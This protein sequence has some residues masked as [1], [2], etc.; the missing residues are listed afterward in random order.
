MYEKI[1]RLHDRQLVD[2]I[3]AS[4]LPERLDL[5]VE[6]A[7]EGAIVEAKELGTDGDD[8]DGEAGEEDVDVTSAKKEKTA[9][10]GLDEDGEGEGEGGDNGS[11]SGSESGSGDVTG[12][13]EGMD[14]DELAA[15][16]AEAG[17][18]GEAIEDKGRRS[19][20]SARSPNGISAE[21]SGAG[22]GQAMDEDD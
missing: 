14:D 9:E 15:L 10:D 19:R 7:E 6:I 22:V 13:E 16:Q 20:R 11:E 21:T 18:E 17:N 8:E 3:D 4:L 2:D 5:P 1:E 12:S